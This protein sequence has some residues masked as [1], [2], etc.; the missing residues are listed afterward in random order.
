MPLIKE[1]AADG[2]SPGSER[3]NPSPGWEREAPADSYF[4]VH[5]IDNSQGNVEGREEA[6]P[7]CSPLPSCSIINN[8]AP[9]QRCVQWCAGASTHR[10]VGKTHPVVS[11]F[12]GNHQINWFPYITLLL[13]CVAR[14]RAHTQTHTHTQQSWEMQVT[15]RWSGVSGRIFQHGLET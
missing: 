5:W 14:A 10:L 7:K 2:I 15:E 6:T 11:N 12:H 4:A 3:V 13:P 1:N 9:A 8:L